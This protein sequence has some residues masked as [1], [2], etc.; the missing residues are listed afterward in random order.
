[1][2]QPDLIKQEKR[3]CLTEYPARRKR[4]TKKQGSPFFVYT[5]FAASITFIRLSAGDTESK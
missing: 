5:H 2:S 1:M 4:Y 3:M